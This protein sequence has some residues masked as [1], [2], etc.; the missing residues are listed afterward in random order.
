MDGHYWDLLLGSTLVPY[1]EDEELPSLLTLNQLSPV[2]GTQGHYVL[3]DPS[4]SLIS[5][6]TDDGCLLEGTASI[7]TVVDD[8]CL[9]LQ[10]EMVSISSGTETGTA[11]VSEA[12]TPGAQ[13]VKELAVKVLPSIDAREKEAKTYVVKNIPRNSTTGMASFKTY[14]S[15][16]LG[17]EGIADIGYYLRGGKRVWIKS[18]GDLVSVLVD[19]DVKG[20]GS[21]WV[22]EEGY[23]DDVEIAPKTKKRRS[24][25]EE[26]QE[27]VQAKFED[28]KKW[29]GTK[30]TSPQYRFWAEALEVGLHTST[31]DPPR[32]RMF[33]GPKTCKKPSELKEA[34]TE[35]AKTLT[36][37]VRGGHNTPPLSSS[38]LKHNDTGSPNVSRTLKVADLKSKYI[39]QIKGLFSL[40]EVGALSQD[41][42]DKQKGIILEQMGLC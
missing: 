29:H 20:R 4:A 37:V 26:R 11:N 21:I 16:Q 2:V 5:A 34:F 1:S 39:Q 18:C 17:V 41:D 13:I 25:A 35:L 22:V 30:Y 36:D 40:Y 10:A 32:G 24:D 6:A 42:F 28:L 14:L 9:Q 12:T 7:S 8:S 23:E 15:E 3:R 31:D 38:P 27:R 33:E 19:I